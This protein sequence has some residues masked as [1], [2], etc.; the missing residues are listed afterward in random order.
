MT[1][2]DSLRELSVPENEKRQQ[3]IQS[4]IKKLVDS[5][6][7]F[8]QSE[9]TAAARLNK[10]CISGY[11]CQFFDCHNWSLLE[12]WEDD[13]F[14]AQKRLKP[15]SYK[16]SPRLLRIDRVCYDKA[17]PTISSFDLKKPYES[18]YYSSKNKKEYVDLKTEDIEK[19]C[20]KIEKLLISLGFKE[21]EVNV[22]K[23]NFYYYRYEEIKTI[24][25]KSK[26]AHKDDAG[27]GKG[28]YIKI[29][30]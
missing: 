28:L 19:L 5:L 7:D 13:S 30:W 18:L 24:F 11:I 9:A 27:S 26:K 16:G 29:C 2:A 23:K 15:G 14:T 20:S 8:I 17:Y 21:Y 3:A 12:Y 1:F 10:N 25:G 6:K 22:V 4:A